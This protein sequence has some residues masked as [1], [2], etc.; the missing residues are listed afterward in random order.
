MKVPVIIVTSDD[1]P[2]TTRRALRL[3]ANTVLLKPVMT[4]NLEKAL[5]K[6]GLP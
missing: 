6:V 4:D 5:K 1:S 2:D 3:G